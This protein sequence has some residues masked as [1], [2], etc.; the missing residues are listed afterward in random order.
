MGEACNAAS[1]RTG[2][3]MEGGATEVLEFA[4]S[5]EEERTH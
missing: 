4:E 1:P 5:I 2:E 3:E